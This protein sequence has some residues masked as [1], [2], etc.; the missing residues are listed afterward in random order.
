MIRQVL[1]AAVVGLGSFALAAIVALALADA[2]WFRAYWWVVDH[3]PW[4]PAPRPLAFLAAGLL[5]AP[6]LCVLFGTAALLSARLRIPLWSGVAAAGILGG[7]A[8]RG[9]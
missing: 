3:S 9:F 4:E 2:G 8:A 1:A 7:A 5:T 6:F